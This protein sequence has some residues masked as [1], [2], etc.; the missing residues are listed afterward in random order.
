MEVS[1]PRLRG[2]VLRLHRRLAV[3]RLIEGLGLGMAV[4][5]VLAA[6][7][8]A[9]LIWR[10]RPALAPASA[11]LGLGAVLG[12]ARAAA[13]LP[14]KLAAAIEADRQLRT[15]DLLATACVLLGRRDNGPL[16]RA[17]IAAA[18]VRAIDLPASAVVLRR[19]RVAHWGAAALAVALAVGLAGASGRSAAVVGPSDIDRPPVRFH[20][21]FEPPTPQS[22]HDRKTLARLP[23]EAESGASSEV[24]APGVGQEQ[25][26]AATSHEAEGAATA[27]H[28]GG[29]GT[30]A[31]V[32]APSLGPT[33]SGPQ[34]TAEGRAERI[35]E[36]VASGRGGRPG[37]TG[38]GDD[39]AHAAS[40]SDRPIPPWRADGWAAARE[41][42][43]AAIRLGRVPD[44]YRSMVRAYFDRN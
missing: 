27:D 6:A 28:R 29:S 26:I 40:L 19:W 2:L 24:S 17:V 38:R 23:T 30:G 36:R 34:P 37:Q 11:A 25:D 7:I 33:A 14:G 35:G 4:G 8:S 21:P 39:A 41:E 22:G 31:A 16:E 12:L 5:A 9:V 43:G 13:R 10:D 42:A 44:A 20:S 32:E 3:V 18:E 1:A 15:A